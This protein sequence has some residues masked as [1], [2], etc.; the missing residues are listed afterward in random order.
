MQLDREY[1][2]TV[3]EYIDEEGEVHKEFEQTTVN[4]WH[5]TDGEEPYLKLYLYHLAA[6]LG[7]PEGAMKTLLGFCSHTDLVDNLWAGNKRGKTGKLINNTKEPP[8]K[9]AAKLY[10]NSEL[11]KDVAEYLGISMPS[12]DRHLRE[13][14]NKGVL[15]HTGRSTYQVNPYYIARGN[16]AEITELRAT[17]DYV[18]GTVTTEMKCLDGDTNETVRVM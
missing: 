11:K 15:K 18:N 8:R 7:L 14:C 1:E 5:E 10:L 16:W 17:F 4:R 2:N 9:R 13:L 3:R 6:F 12:I